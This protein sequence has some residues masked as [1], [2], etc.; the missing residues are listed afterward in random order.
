MIRP[1]A[2]PRVWNVV[3]WLYIGSGLLF[4]A[5]ISLGILNVFSGE[6]ISRGQL[7]A[8]F[9]AGTIGWVTLSVIATALWMYASQGP[10]S[11][12]YV[13]WAKVLT[14]VGLTSVAGYIAAFGTVFNANDMYW[15]LPLFG[16]PTWAVIVGGFL[17]TA[18]NLKRQVTVTTVHLLLF[19]ALLVASLGA[20]MGV[21]WGLT[22]NGAISPYPA[23]SEPVGAHAAP[24]DMYLALAFAAFLELFLR[25]DDHARWTR[26][27]MWQMVLGVA[28]AFLVA[29]GTFF[30]VFQI[31]PLALGLFLASLV[32]YMIR[33]GWRAFVTNPASGG[34]SAAVFFGGIF[35]PVYVLLFVLFVF[36]FFIPERP[37]PHWLGVLFMHTTF[38]GAGTNLILAL[39]SSYGGHQEVAKKLEPWAYWILNVGMLLFFAGVYFA[40]DRNAALLMAVGVLL[41]LYV[42]WARLGRSWE[43]PD[44]S[45][46]PPPGVD[47][48]R[49]PSQPTTP[50]G[51]AAPSEEPEPGP[52][53]H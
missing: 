50:P 46:G 11:D 38:V 15:M 20:T 53:A 16:I 43:A 21:L 2:D 37:I 45:G 14:I 51:G 32:I 49:P 18:L 52:G 4:L 25:K 24:M 17:F 40:G 33:I 13:F 36:V 47:P 8:H 29:A 26:P 10:A 27:G 30:G 7:L 41:G 19:G 34:R 35:F 44:T 3:R 9:H 39:Q 6:I 28:A 48:A 1:N 22:L 5:N 42:A 31:A 12:Q 23:G